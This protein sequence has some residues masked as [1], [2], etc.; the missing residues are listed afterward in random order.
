M[1]FF[2]SSVCVVFGAR[3]WASL[4]NKNTRQN[5]M[6]LMGVVVYI[7]FCV[8]IW[9]Y[10]SWLKTILISYFMCV[11]WAY[12]NLFPIQQSMF[13]FFQVYYSKKWKFTL[14]QLCLTDRGKC[15]HLPAEFPWESK[16][17]Y[18]E[19]HSMTPFQF[20][21]SGS[22]KHWKLNDTQSGPCFHFPG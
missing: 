22:I 21:L 3:K 6:D 5:S 13:D 7:F 1:F 14:R 16:P 17:M 12:W 11:E 8:C 19:C 9:L 2:R 15:A 10:Y 20:Q 4:S 18:C